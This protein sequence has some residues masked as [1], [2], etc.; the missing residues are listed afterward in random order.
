MSA[1]EEDKQLRIAALRN[2]EEILLSRNR[3]EKELRHA[4]AALEQKNQELQ[5]Q[6]EW[7]QV[8]L[9]SI[10]DA[11]ITTNAQGVVTFMNPIAEVMTGWESAEAVGLPLSRI[12]TVINEHTGEP[13]E[14][15][16]AQVIRDGRNAGLAE[17]RS[18]VRRDGAVTAIEDTAGP[19]RDRSGKLTGAVMVFHDVTA[20]RKAEA[21]LNASEV[22]YRTIFNQA[23]VGIAV[24]DL[25]GRFIQVNQKF[26]DI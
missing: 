17:H 14:H 10:G 24:T 26:G 9:S 2:A 8:T 16:V 1:N 22:R 11:V 5:Q 7:F 19:I 25:Y 3:V 20:Q 23:A 21:A 4:N 12:F 6:R 15:Q 18:L 13:V